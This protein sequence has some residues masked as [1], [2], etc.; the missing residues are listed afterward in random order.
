ML[1]TG[2]YINLASSLARR[3]RMEA[4]FSSLGLADRYQRFEAIRGEGAKEQSETTLPGGQLGCWLSHLA[5]W[6]QAES[7][8]SHLHVLEDDAALSPLLP[9]VLDELQLDESSWDL[10]FTDVYFHPPPTPEQFAQLCSARG[11]FL[12]E[13]R[14]SLIDL[15]QLAFTG[16][17]SYLVN[18]NCLKR[19]GELLQGRWQSNQ[20]IDV[21]LQQLIRRGELR[22]RVAFPFLST[23]APEHEQSTTGLQGPAIKALDA[24]RKAWF[25]AADPDAIRRRTIDCNCHASSD[26][27]LELYLNSLRGVLGTLQSGSE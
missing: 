9:R 8:G 25:Y 21:V 23:I 15:R 17:T 19:L 3:K 26:A 27:L 14:V 10:I 22:A 6:R 12:K 2:L 24:F 16:T 11:A 7:K 1:Y 13:K 20:T 4:Q 5:I 18:Q